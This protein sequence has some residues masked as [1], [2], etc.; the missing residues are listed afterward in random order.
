MGQRIFEKE[1]DKIVREGLDNLREEFDKKL[2]NLTMN[3]NIEKSTK[4]SAT[5]MM[6]MKERNNCIEKIKTE[7]K[8]NMLK[9][10]VAPDK[11]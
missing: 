1:K 4:I 3:L 8:E 9:T 5:R 10:I 7:S 2:L 6:R 11:F